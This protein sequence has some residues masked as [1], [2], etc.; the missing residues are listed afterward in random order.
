MQPPTAPPRNQLTAAQVTALIR[1]A[2]GVEVAA[3][4]E[5]LDVG[6]NVLADLTDVFGGGQVRRQAFADL[7]G[8]AT[9]TVEGPLDWGTAI[10]RPYM[11]LASPTI[12]ARFNVG[13][14]YT[15]TP[16]TQ[17]GEDPVTYAVEGIDILDGLNDTVG[18]AYA[19]AAGAPYLATVEGIL[20]QRG[21]TR[22]LIDQ[23]AAAS[24]LPSARV[25]AMDDNATWLTIVND[26][27]GAVAYQGVWSDWDG[28]LRVQPYASPTVRPSEWVYDVARLTSMLAPERSLERD[29]YRAPNRWVFYRSNNVDGPAPTEGNGVFTFINQSD[30]HTS[31][32]ARGGRVITRPV[33]LD[34]AD[35]AALVAAAQVTI[36]ADLR[37]KSTLAVASAPNPLHWHFDRVTIDDPAV[38]SAT[39]ALSTQW[40]LPLDGGDMTHEM[41]L[42]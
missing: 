11:I 29:Y 31:I 41:T 21:Y 33:P 35:H 28:Q 6:L 10:L 30:G 9:L 12:T 15:S 42:L 25:W 20:L 8:S 26:L 7:H 36:D 32:D 38:G 18:E 3:G 2:P 34:V 17:L 13:A 16:K 19:V 37:L 23:S 1:D 39:E 14:Y 22:Y 4:C 40:T 5:L 27:L 24:V